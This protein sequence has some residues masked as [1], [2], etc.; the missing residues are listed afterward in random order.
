MTA[1]LPA[2]LCL[3]FLVTGIKGQED[4]DLTG[5]LDDVT[6]KPTPHKDPTTHKDRTPHKEFNPTVK[7]GDGL[8]PA[9]SAPKLDPKQDD[10]LEF[11]LDDALG[12]LDDVPTKKSQPD[13]GGGGAGGGGGGSSLF[14]FLMFNW[15]KL[16]IVFDRSDNKKG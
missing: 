5:A 4:F 12:G 9:T 6:V 15:D 1:R 14:S 2:L 3:L 13:Q 16:L 8:K 11:N 10:D 7:P